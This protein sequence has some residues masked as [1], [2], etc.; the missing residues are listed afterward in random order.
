MRKRWQAL[1][2]LG[3][4]LVW[5]GSVQ[6]AVFWSISDDQGRQ[7]WLLG[8]LHS[9]RAELLEIPPELGRAMGQADRLALELVPDAGML[10]VLNRAMHCPDECLVRALDREL[11]ERAA[12][13]LQDHYGLGERDIARMQPWAVATT[14]AVP[15][16][17]TGLFMDLYLSHRAGSL[18]LEVIGLESVEEQLAF[19]SGMAPAMQV[20]MIRHAVEDHAHT[21]A[22][23]DEL[24]DA[25]LANDLERLVR[26]AED[27][28]DGL[29]EEISAYIERYGLA[30]RN[31]L[32]FER[33]LPY[34]RQGHL[35][36]AV[37]SLHL[38]GE[39]GLVQ[40][41]KEAGFEVRPVLLTR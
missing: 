41:L 18:G 25:Y 20:E 28:M 17:E 4:A 6:A 31:R 32:M 33:A 40:L 26:A 14:L 39:T 35:I 11:Y 13:L 29:S 15:P 30:R 16:A 38:A 8:T 22:A 27:R 23:L 37:G 1:A 2:A 36:I 5:T 21:G 7:S 3:L 10:G 9:E 19:L 24:I 34:L 12:G